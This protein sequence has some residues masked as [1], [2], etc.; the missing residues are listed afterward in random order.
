MT[1][2]T[3]ESI[4]D[5]PRRRRKRTVSVAEAIDFLEFLAPPSLSSPPTP[6]GLQAGAPN[7]EIRAVVVAPMASYTAL[8]TAASRRHTLLVTAAPLLTEPIMAVRRDEAVGSK[9]AYLLEHRINL[10]VLPTSY[11]SV[12]G[13]FDDSL[14][15]RLGLAA[16][17]ALVAT[18]SEEQFK[19]AVYTPL[20]A[21]ERVMAAA[22][23]AGAGN[24]GNYSHCSF[25]TSGQG[26]FMPKNGARPHTGAVG[27]LE[28]VDEIRIE[29]LV[30][31]RE[32]KGVVAAIL[33]AH[34]YEEV[35]YD[36][37]PVKNP[38]ALYGRG[39][40]GELPLSVSLETV[41]AQVQDSL[42]ADS[43]RLSHKPEFSIGTLAVASGMSDGLFW[44]ANRGGAGALVTGGVSLQDLMHAD[45]STTVVIDVGYAASVKPGLL[46]LA[47]QVRN[48]FGGDGVETLY[49]A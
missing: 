30:P 23:E 3:G 5:R 2:R 40:I 41:L 13:G 27:K 43:V 17:S 46:R 6:Y 11:A 18:S 42:E 4:E 15:E 29:M 37:F 8:S 7:S 12:P 19:I 10:Y 16:S 26:T 48:T 20:E 24:I 1:R 38:G 39:R 45:N 21:V 33:D 44:S 28:R 47:A 25:Q 31:E 32:I 49:C 34:P 36:V 22:S 14:A 35:A 9:L